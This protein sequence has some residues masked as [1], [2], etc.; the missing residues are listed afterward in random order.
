MHRRYS[1]SH[2]PVGLSAMN[3]G[4][5]GGWPNAQPSPGGADVATMGASAVPTVPSYLE[6][7]QLS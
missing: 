6:L 3:G 2:L 4:G 7:A 5:M 1:W